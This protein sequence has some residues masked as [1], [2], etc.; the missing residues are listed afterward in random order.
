MSPEAR[1]LTPGAGVACLGQGPAA[2]GRGGPRAPEEKE[3][4]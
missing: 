3:T 1:A 4:L 2:S